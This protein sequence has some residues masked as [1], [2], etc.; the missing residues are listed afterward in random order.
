DPHDTAARNGLEVQRPASPA[1]DLYFIPAGADQED[2]P[3]HDDDLVLI[4]AG[5]DE[6]LVLRLRVLQRGAGT[7]K[8]RR[9]RGVHDQRVAPGWIGWRLVEDVRPWKGVHCP[10][11]GVKQGV[12]SRLWRFGEAV[13][14]SR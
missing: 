8:S 11:S 5:P 6:D 4:D 10:L 7:F 1:E 13:W 12:H 14:R 3:V 2:R 9:V